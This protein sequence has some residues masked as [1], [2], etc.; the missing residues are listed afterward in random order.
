M[1]RVGRPRI[2][3]YGMGQFG[4]MIA[5]F[6]V[7]KGWS[8]VAAFNRAGPKVGEDIGR[9]AGLERTLLVALTGYGRPSDR[10]HAQEAGFDE[11]L[12][13]PAI[14]EDVYALALKSRSLRTT[15]PRPAG[16]S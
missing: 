6:A 4:K 2:A 12:V 3:I 11:F 1:R 13:K 14:P 10:Q 8:I 15:D 5:R 16:D 9:I 7:Q